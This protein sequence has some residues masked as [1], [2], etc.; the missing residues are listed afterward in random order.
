MPA[1]SAVII[2]RDLRVAERAV[3]M[4]LFHVQDLAAQGQN[5]LEFAVAAAAWREPP[6]E[7]PSTMNSSQYATRRVSEQSAS[8]PGRDADSS[9]V[10]LP[11]GLAR[12]ARRLSCARGADALV[13]DLPRDGGVFLQIRPELLG[14]RRVLDQR[15]DVGCCPSFVFVW[16]S[17][18]G[19]TSL[20]EMTHVMPS[21]KSSPREGRVVRL[22]KVVAPR[23]V[24]EH[25][26]SARA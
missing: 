10:F 25:A 1:P 4:R 3:D 13:D 20:T 19:S 22:Q 9:T 23:V 16:P 8:L 6:A 24:V 21:R 5:G 17:N 18:C 26:A 7:S 2:A 14:H 12:L 15:A 11:R